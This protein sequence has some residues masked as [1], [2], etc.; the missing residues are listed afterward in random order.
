MRTQRLLPVCL[1]VVLAGV[2]TS[3]GSGQVGTARTPGGSITMLEAEP[4]GGL[5]PNS[6]FVDSSRVPLAM[7]FETLVER[8]GSGALV[9]ALASKWSVTRGGTV[10]TFT[11]RPGIKFSDGTPIRP[12]D[13]RFSIDRMRTGLTLKG[14]LSGVKSVSVSGPTAVRVTMKSPTRV[15]PAVLARAGQA[16]ILPMKQVQTN[17]NYFS[18]PTIGSGPWVL[19]QYVPKGHMTFTANQ[20]YFH[21]P[22]ITTINYTFSD[23]QTSNAA[24]VESG[25]ADLANVN[26]ADVAKLKDNTNVNVV[27]AD[28][29]SL[30]GFG[31]DKTKPPF[32]DVRVREAFAYADDRAGKQKACWYGTGAVTNGSLLRPWDP[33]YTKI[34]TYAISRSA[35]LAKAGQLLDAAGWKLASNGTREAS[36]VQGVADGTPLAVTVPYESNWPA[37]QCHVLVLQQDLAKIGV[38]ITP[39]AYDPTTFYTQAGAG[40]FEMWHFGAGAANADDLYLNWFHSGGAL[41]AVTTQLNDPK[42]DRLVDEALATTSAA[43]AKRLYSQ[44]EHWQATNVPMLADGYQWIQIATSKRLHNYRPPIDDDSR[45]LVYAT[46]T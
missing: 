31:F 3:I 16:V 27:Q 46:A 37:A 20:Y 44:L 15:L 8:N 26:Y 40:K 4:T 11:L 14:A 30:V 19:T 17:K 45:S 42:I 10:Y 35:S 25:S 43:K 23:D 38:K 22:Q 21:H 39:Q 13:V 36:G 41:T 1:A 5:D 34:S 7:I 24:A 18:D 2:I 29:L 6:A 12:A 28:T 9:G 33:D 32:S